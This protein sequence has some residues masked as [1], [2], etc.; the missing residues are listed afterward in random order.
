VHGGE[1][2]VEVEDSVWGGVREGHAG[3]VRDGGGEVQDEHVGDDVEHV[4]VLDEQSARM[5]R[6]M[7]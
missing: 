3:G 2:E 4:R 1:E 5:T 7:L 6:N